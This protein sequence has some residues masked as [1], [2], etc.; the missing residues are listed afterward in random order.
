MND[1]FLFYKDIATFTNQQNGLTNSCYFDKI[2]KP[3]AFASGFVVL[4]SLYHAKI[5]I[6]IDKGFGD[7]DVYHQSERKIMSQG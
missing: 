2:T 7:Y 4:L 5:Y 1:G 6:G 3:L